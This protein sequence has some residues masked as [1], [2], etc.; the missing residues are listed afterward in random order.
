MGPPPRLLGYL[1][2]A[3]QIDAT[4]VDISAG[5]YIPGA[6]EVYVTGIPSSIDYAVGSMRIGEL[7]IDYTP[8]LGAN[9][10]GGMG[11]AITVYGTQPALGGTMLGETLI[12]KTEMFLGKEDVGKVKIGAAQKIPPRASKRQRDLQRAPGSN[13]D[14]ES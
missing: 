8:S 2:G 3:G 5:M 12:D 4:G 11:A 13:F 10:Q 9:D 1:A 14:F 6:S 7:N